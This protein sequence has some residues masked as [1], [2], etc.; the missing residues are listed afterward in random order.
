MTG[1]STRV[2]DRL[3]VCSGWFFMHDVAAMGEIEPE[4]VQARVYELQ[5]VSIS[6]SPDQWWRDLGSSRFVVMF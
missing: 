1:S 6:E 4:R 5:R 3:S 2:R